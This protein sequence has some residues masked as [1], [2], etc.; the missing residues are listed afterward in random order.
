MA[1]AAVQAVEYG[2]W[3]TTAFDTNTLLD[4][5]VAACT[6]AS[7]RAARRAIANAAERGRA[8]RRRRRPCKAASSVRF[9]GLGSLGG[10]AR[11]ANRKD[12]WLRSERSTSIRALEVVV[13]TIKGQL[14][15]NVSDE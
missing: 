5:V 1:E 2:S 4:Q 10:Q 7:T 15:W 14:S 13:P 3:K 12:A 11:A 8:A 9:I 6:G